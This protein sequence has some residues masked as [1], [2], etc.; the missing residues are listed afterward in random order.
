MSIQKIGDASLSW[1][2]GIQAKNAT[3]IAD[4]TNSSSAANST[5]QSAASQ[6][7]DA[8]QSTTSQ[9]SKQKLKDAQQAADAMQEFVQPLNNTLQFSVDQDSGKT[10]VKV[11]DSATSKVIKQIPSEEAVALAKALDKLKGLLIQQKA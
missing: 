5:T 1:E 2:A 11:V 7:I 3:P 10:V 6:P 9:E 8:T 4:V